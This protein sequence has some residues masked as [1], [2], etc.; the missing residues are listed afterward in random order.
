MDNCTIGTAR[1]PARR[2]GLDT[3]ALFG[4]WIPKCVP[5]MT[6]LASIKQAPLAHK[7]A[8]LIT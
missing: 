3:W 7:G 8:I 6:H 2:V 1:A 5:T 4:L